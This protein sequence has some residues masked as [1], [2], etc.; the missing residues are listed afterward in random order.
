MEIV[1]REEA[2]TLRYRIAEREKTIQQL[3]EEV[4]KLSREVQVLRDQ[5][6]QQSL[7][8]NCS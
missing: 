5:L 7:P 2:A 4:A 3:L 6:K 8:L 1:L